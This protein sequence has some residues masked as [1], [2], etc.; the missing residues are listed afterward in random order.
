[1]KAVIQ[2]SELPLSINAELP[3]KL[4]RGFNIEPVEDRCID[5]HKV[6]CTVTAEAGYAIPVM[7]TCTD[8]QFARL[9]RKFGPGIM[10]IKLW[11][12]TALAGGACTGAQCAG[13]TTID[14]TLVID[15]PMTDDHKSGRHLG[16]NQEAGTADGHIGG[17]FLRGTIYIQGAGVIGGVGDPHLM[18]GD[19][20]DELRTFFIQFHQHRLIAVI[21]TRGGIALGQ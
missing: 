16:L 20:A 6:Q 1:M 4:I 9:H 18:P 3:G 15:P 8:M 12:F 2:S 5:R 10:N 11:S 17:R 7:E 19:E 21:H 13:R 14:K